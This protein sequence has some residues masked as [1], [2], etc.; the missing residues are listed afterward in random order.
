[1]SSVG[2]AFVPA[3]FG[4]K[5]DVYDDAEKLTK[6]EYHGEPLTWKDMYTK[7]H[8]G[9][10]LQ[11]LLIGIVYGGAIAVIYPV[12]QL[13][14]DSPANVLNTAN[15]F[16]ILGYNIKFLYGFTSDSYPIFGQRRR[17]YVLIGWIGCLLATIGCACMCLFGKQKEACYIS[18]PDYQIIVPNATNPNICAEQG[19]KVYKTPEFS[20]FMFT[21]LLL[22]QN[23]TY[24]IADVAS[25]S[26]SI[27]WAKREP[28][29]S[30]GQI[31]SNNYVFRMVGFVISN[32]VLGFGLNYKAYGGPWESGLSLGG[33]YII[34]S[35]LILVSLPFF[36]WIEDETVSKVDTPSLGTQFGSVR[37]LFS[38]KAYAALILFSFIW[39]MTSCVMPEGQTLVSGTWVNLTPLVSALNKAFGNFLQGLALYLA[40]RFFRGF[41]WRKLTVA[42][43]IFVVIS[44]CLYIP[45]AYGYLRSP[46][47]YIFVSSDT[48]FVQ[49]INYMV[50]LW[51]T[52]EIAPYGLEGTTYALVTSIGNVAQSL[53]QAFITNM[54]GK[55]WPSQANLEG[56]N[57]A[58]DFMLNTVVVCLIMFCGAFALPLLPSQKA[59]ARYRRDNWGL[60]KTMGDIALSVVAFLCAWCLFIT[61][62]GMSCP[63]YWLYGGPGDSCDST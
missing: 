32:F 21:L 16:V 53:S 51:A 45:M 13:N 18:E 49:N 24:M 47:F 22:F 6:E 42:T 30:R 26:L 52:N 46:L 36:Y 57:V 25:D 3:N 40:G 9:L 1:M 2:Q 39:N 29:E 58:Q 56:A 8:F 43:I 17:P 28:E 12:L 19:L 50:S 10:P 27:E 11:Y 35:C 60:N 15:V 41:N 23:L 33:Y 34:V 7:R 63:G 59:N 54:V 5:V 61:F 20:P 37:S 55:I 31:Q 44:F 4:S 48:S 62:M 14:L 38:M